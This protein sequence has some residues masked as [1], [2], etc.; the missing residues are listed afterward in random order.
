MSWRVVLW[1]RDR[2][3]VWS[4]WAVYP[5]DRVRDAMEEARALGASNPELFVVLAAGRIPGM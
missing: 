4:E 3:G 2:R 5:G 1:R